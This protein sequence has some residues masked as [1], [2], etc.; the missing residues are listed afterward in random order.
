MNLKLLLSVLLIS[1]FSS[2]INAQPVLKSYAIYR[3]VT[4]IP[5]NPYLT[6]SAYFTY[7]G[8]RACNIDNLLRN[9]FQLI[10][11]FREDMAPYDSANCYHWNYTTSTLVNTKLLRW[12]NT[13]NKLIKSCEL[14]STDTTRY[15]YNIAGDVISIRTMTTLDTFKYSG[16]NKIERS[17]YSYVSST[18]K[19]IYKQSYT[20]N[21]SNDCTYQADSTWDATTST[22]S[23]YTI[24]NFTYNTSHQ[25]TFSNSEEKGSPS[26]YKYQYFYNYN[27]SS[28]LDTIRLQWLNT[29]WKDLQKK[30]NTYNSSGK[31]I[32][33]EIKQWYT[34]TWHSSQKASMATVSPTVNNTVQQ[35][36]NS[37][38]IPDDSVTIL[39]Y[40][41]PTNI[42]NRTLAKSFDCTL[43]P[44]PASSYLNI[45]LTQNGKAPLSFAIFNIQGA[46][47]TKWTT[48]AVDDY[49]KQIPTDN[50]PAGEYILYINNSKE[51]LYKP[52][53]ISH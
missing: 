25:V 5:P 20:Y 47:I 42:E 8:G 35:L 39:Y 15:L 28:L 34:G 46:L 16:G 53:S 45:A 3:G 4:S 13:S 1:F 19:L 49:S 29:T 23:D 24:Q 37:T 41:L 6:D 10:D 43:Y 21:T 36:Y 7:S 51:D 30:I 18:W 31:L 32:M 27:G 2:T 12:Y 40:I 52:F 22:L 50:L 33:T 9:D 48:E 17:M 44:V 26:N 11:G 14:G 38:W